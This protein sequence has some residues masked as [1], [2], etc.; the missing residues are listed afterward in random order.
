MASSA[1]F[2]LVLAAVGFVALGSFFVASREFRTG[3]RVLSTPTGRVS[4]LLTTAETV[5]ELHGTAQEA[6]ETLSGPFSGEDCL[7]CKTIVEE[8]EST[9][10]G[11]SWNE[12]DSIVQSI[13]F[14]LE[15]G[16]GSVLVDPRL[17]EI[18]ITGDT[19][20]IRVDG[21]TSPPDRVQRYI[22]DN[23]EVS[24]ENTRLDLRLFS[25]S[26][27]ADRRYTERRIRP[28]GEVYV[29]GQARREAGRAGS[30]NSVVG[31]GSDAPLFLIGDDSARRTGIRALWQGGLY[32]VPG[33][34]VALA[35]V[36]VF[37][38]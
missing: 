34:I 27:G 17:A 22:E 5:I 11:G 6:G 16:S 8:Y 26:T 3:Y 35:L 19:E 10:H 25:V 1:F 36:V 24:C 9:Q 31:Y 14:V 21:G 12:I 28:G 32:L 2:V 37:V 15:D 18:R 7:V 30:I 20:Q 13:P 4:N 29:L 23:D 38:L 33:L